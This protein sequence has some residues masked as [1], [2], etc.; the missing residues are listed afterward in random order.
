MFICMWM[1]AVL[2]VTGSP[3][4]SPRQLSKGWRLRTSG[5]NLQRSHAAYR[6]LDTKHDGLWKS[7][8]AKGPIRPEMMRHTFRPA[9]SASFQKHPRG[10]I[11]ST[12]RL[13]LHSWSARHGHCW[14]S[15]HRA[16]ISPS[17]RP[18]PHP[19]GSPKAVPLW[20]DLPHRSPKGMSPK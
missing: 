10:P 16:Q 6:S 4:L 8:P 7:L 18:S 14:E 1:N 11:R 5:M 13:P 15:R 9:A 19:S 2:Y 20:V 12:Q 17:K 3:S